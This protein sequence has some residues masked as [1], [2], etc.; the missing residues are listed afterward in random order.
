MGLVRGRDARSD[1]LPRVP[2]CDHVHVLGWRVR[3]ARPTGSFGSRWRTRMSSDPIRCGLGSCPRGPRALR[4]TR[5]SKRVAATSTAPISATRSVGL[6]VE[7]GMPLRRP[8]CPVNF[9]QVI[10][11]GVLVFFPS[12]G[13][14]ADCV[15]AWQVSVRRG[16]AAPQRNCGPARSLKKCAVRSPSVGEAQRPKAVA[17]NRSVWDRLKQYKHPVIEPRRKQEFA[18]VRLPLLRARL[19]PWQRTPQRAHGARA[20][21]RPGWAPCAGVGGI[22]RTC[23]PR[24][25]GP[26]CRV[27]RQGQRRH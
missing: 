6:G 22:L 1:V 2:W 19:P 12:Y 7:R 9:C 4:S 5:R 18:D 16:P 25:V 14:M 23:G 27:P 17:G 13:V 20:D 11:D 10:P 8:L 3:R 15:Q 24:R 26:V 21:V